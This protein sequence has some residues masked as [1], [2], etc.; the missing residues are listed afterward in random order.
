MCVVY[1][2]FAVSA[3]KLCL[4]D[5]QLISYAEMVEQGR[6]ICYAVDIPVIGDGDTGYGNAINVKRTIAGCAYGPA[7]LLLHPEI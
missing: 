1:T 5:T 3:S 7:S 6:Q 4:P 2:R